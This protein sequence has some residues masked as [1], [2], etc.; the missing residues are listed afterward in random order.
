MATKLDP[1][2]DVMYKVKKAILESR[3]EIPVQDGWRLLCLK[4]FLAQKYVLEAQHQD[5]DELDKLIDSI[6]IS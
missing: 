2:S 6:C 3:A 5:T 1:T 4:K